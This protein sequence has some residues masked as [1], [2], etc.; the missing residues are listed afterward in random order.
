MLWGML[1]CSQ[2]HEKCSFNRLHWQN[3]TIH[4]QGWLSN[5]YYYYYYYYYYA[6]D[7]A[8]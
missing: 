8:R 5:G 6:V 3:I 7:D 4:Y 2:E 1:A